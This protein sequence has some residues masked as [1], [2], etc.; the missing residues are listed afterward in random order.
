MRKFFLL[1]AV[2]LFA[3]A[4]STQAASWKI[5]KTHSS[6][7][8]AV[9]HLMVSKVRGSFGDFE[10]TLNFDPKNVSGGS[11]EFSIKVASIDTDNE[12][13]D[14]HLKSPDFF[15]VE[16]YPTMTFKSKKV[17]PGDEGEFKIVGDLTIKETTKEVTFDVEFNGMID[18]MKT[19]RAGFSATAKINR[20]DFGVSFSKVI[21]TGGLVVD[22]MVKIIFEIEAVQTEG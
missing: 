6:A 11:V 5:D 10:G 2:A 19:T 7:G 13:R 9:K 21:E 12:K 18:F 14:N 3:F 16:N 8:F 15:D 17:V 4:A 1:T 20:Q 22:D